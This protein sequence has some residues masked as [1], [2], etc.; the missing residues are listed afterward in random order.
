LPR[1]VA[2]T[3]NLLDP[4]FRL[5]D[6]PSFAAQYEDIF[7]WECYDF[8]YDRPAPT[9]V[10]GG[11]NV[12]SA[13]IWWR[14]R[15]PK[16]RVI[17]FEPDPGVFKVLAWNTRFLEG[18]ELHQCALGD[19]SPTAFWSEGTDASRLGPDEDG[20]GRAISVVTIALSEVVVR[21]GH[22]DLLKLDIEGAE[23]DVL[24][25]AEDALQHVDCIF[26]EYHSFVGRRQR[27]G[28][29]LLLLQH[30]GFRYY[31]E[32]PARRTRPFRG[33]PPDR[34]IDFQCNIFAQRKALA[35]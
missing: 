9:I 21:L 1:G 28:R 22:V 16:S 33:V 13:T 29:L 25:E 4:P 30:Q 17:A 34:G 26:V 27:L 15:W 11:A 35:G 32:S 20:A 2:T 6:G 23:T 18:V 12:G 14:A 8:P 31:I 10:D 5:V 19:G 24:E 3:T 7:V